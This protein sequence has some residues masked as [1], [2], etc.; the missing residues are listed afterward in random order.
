MA[1]MVD[2]VAS[3]VV[4]VA[5]ME[6]AAEEFIFVADSMNNLAFRADI[7]HNLASALVAK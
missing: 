2:Q 3:M 4:Q 7:V 1:L 6:L 5:S